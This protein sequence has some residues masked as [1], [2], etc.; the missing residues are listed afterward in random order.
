MSGVEMH[1]TELQNKI[2]G[3]IKTGNIA[4]LEI[5]LEDKLI[6]EIINTNIIDENFE[7]PIMLAIRYDN[8]NDI[9]IMKLL[10]NKGANINP[11]F[12]NSNTALS[13]AIES[14]KIDKLKILLTYNPNINSKK[15][16]ISY[17]MLAVVNKNYEITKLLINSGADVN[18]L[19]SNYSKY[20]ALHYSL[21][22]NSPDIS[23]LLIESG[24]D[25]NISKVSY[26]T[27]YV[28]TKHSNVEMMEIL[29]SKGADPDNMAMDGYF[30]LLISVINRDISK[31][32]LLLKYNVNI[33][34]KYC[35]KLTVL[36]Y[37]IYDWNNSVEDCNILELLLAS[38]EIDLD[39]MIH[40]KTYLMIAVDQGHLDIVRLLI[41]YGADINFKNDYCATALMYAKRN[42]NTEMINYLLK[43]GAKDSD[44]M[45]CNVKIILNPKILELS[46]QDLLDKKYDSN[47][48]L[49][50]NIH[51]EHVNN[52]LN[53]YD[54]DNLD[55]K[56][57]NDDDFLGLSF[58]KNNWRMCE[59]L[60]C[61]NSRD[62]E[63]IIF[64]IIE[65]RQFSWLKV[66]YENNPEI[67]NY[68]NYD[69][70]TPLSI[71]NREGYD[72]IRMFFLNYMIH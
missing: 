54:N 35:S 23:K 32:K 64:P 65:D 21:I 56:L 20:T 46:E 42:N 27:L 22:H 25:I 39:Y 34:R 45:S 37:L 71:S 28:A 8:D 59:L 14:N 68:R 33:N 48:I 44:T 57:P 52:F 13:I 43:N 9:S 19:Y 29:L 5:L 70:E 12:S 4:E 67:I 63:H 41:K 18:Y 26:S 3:A 17:L 6:N 30:P 24:A 1:K 60:F 31:I 53:N 62:Y 72:D 51:P 7:T 2:V 40:R 11:N 69:G 15:R 38:R 47:Y 36:H 10:L 50:L 66:L 16:Q 49:L 58:I 61:Y 55:F